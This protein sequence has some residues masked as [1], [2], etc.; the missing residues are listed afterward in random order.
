[1]GADHDLHR[2]PSQ[3]ACG[4]L[5]GSDWP[6]STLA[7]GGAIFPGQRRLASGFRMFGVYKDFTLAWLGWGF[8]ASG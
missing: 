1:M 5:L 3:T 6:V 7:L 2:Q 8:E 4:A